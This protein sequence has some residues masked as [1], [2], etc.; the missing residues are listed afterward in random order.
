MAP[1]VQKSKEAKLLA[2]QSA[3]KG[4]GKKKWSKGKVREKKNYRVVFN[5]EILQRLMKEVPRKMKVI[6]T[7]TLI[8]AYKI[9]GSVARRGIKELL[10]QNLIKPVLINAKGAVYTSS[11]DPKKLKE[12]AAAAAASEKKRARVVV[13]ESSVAGNIVV[14]KNTETV[15]AILTGKKIEFTAV[16]LSVSSKDKEY[17]HTH[18]K[19]KDKNSLPQIFVDGSYKGGFDE[20]N[21]A[22]EDGAD[23]VKAL[24]GV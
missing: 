19:S 14:K 2:A 24:L 4:K 10:L 5:A 6:T 18:S 12:D 7:Y 15:K 17:M 16:D 23:A 20:L 3:S 1:K 22:N 11:L 8:E 9:N 21:E 13:Y